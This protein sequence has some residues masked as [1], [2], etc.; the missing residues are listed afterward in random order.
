VAYFITH[1]D[2]VID[3]VVPITQWPL[4]ENGRLRMTKS[5]ALPWTSNLTH[6]LSS[7]EQKAIDG[8]EIL[9]DALNIPHDIIPQLGENDRSATGF[10]PPTEFWDVVK[11]FFAHPDQSIRGW[12][13]AAHAQQRVLGAVR[14][15]GKKLSATT[16]IALWYGPVQ[17]FGQLGKPQ[18][19]VNV[20]G[21]LANPEQIEAAT[22]SI[23]SGE[24]RP[25]AL[26]GDLHRL[27]QAG[28]FNAELSWDEVEPGENTL[29]ITVVSAAGNTTT[30]SVQIVDGLWH[31]EE[32]G[33]RTAEP[34]YDRVLSMGDE[35]WTNY[36]TTMRLTIHG[37]TPS[38]PGPPTYNVTH[39]GVAMR[40]RGHHTDGLQPSRKWFPLGAQGEFL[41]KDN[42]E[43]CQWRI[44]FDGAKDK[45]HKYADGRNTLVIGKPICI[46]TQVAT[47]P[48]GCSR[49]RFKQWTDGQPE[50]TAWDVEGFE[51]DDYLSG[52][53]CIVPHNSDVTIHQV[54]IEPLAV[55]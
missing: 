49:Y 45:P 15:T 5:L 41:L 9:S 50:P 23:N 10:L 29:T 31:L 38:T 13:T 51:A 12:E 43:D 34:Y 53:L 36:Q 40:W 54:C 24:Q 42:L 32:T 20:L 2:V 55:V 52:A 25:L 47:L 8:A 17:H 21:N 44:L 3:P 33:V 7:T 28:D 26:G 6:I 35:T 48:D 37:F 39:F 16:P 46:K 22:F 19:W 11:D 4:S 1:P 30:A 14:S 18:R 27:A